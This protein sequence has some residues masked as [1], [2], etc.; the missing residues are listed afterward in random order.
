MRLSAEWL[1]AGVLAAVALG[2]AALLTGCDDDDPLSGRPEVQADLVAPP[3]VP[4][5]IR[6]G[7]AHVVVDLFVEE[8]EVEIAPGVQYPVWTFNGSVPGPMIR[9]RVGDQVEVR[10]RNPDSSTVV[11]NIDLHSVNGP[12]GGAGATNVAPGEESGFFFEAKAPGLYVY[13]CA[14][15]IVADHIANGMYGA[16]LVEPTDG[17]DEVDREYYVGQS[18]FYTTGDNGDE[19]EQQLDPDKLLAEA[20]EYV[21]FN[22]HAN[23]L[24][25]AG[26]LTA[27]TGERVRL[28]VA[29]GGPNFVSSF[30]VIGEIFDRIY[31]LGSF[32]AADSLPDVQTVLVP[33]GGSAVVE[34]KVDVPGDYRLVDHSLSRVA[35]GAL[36]ILRVSG[37]DDPQ[38]FRPFEGVPAG[39]GHDVV[40]AASGDG[41]ATDGDGGTGGDGTVVAMKD[42][43]FEPSELTA[44]AGTAVTFSLPNEG[45]VPHNMRIAGPDDEYNT[46]DDIVSDPEI[47]G[48]GDDGE[49]TWDLPEAGDFRFRC[50]IHPVEMVGTITV[51]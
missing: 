15:G 47:I 21:L 37:E 19:G 13:H 5:P 43:L 24:Q 28:Y 31:N 18:E 39:D 35:K 8:K 14:A 32:D 46:D 45:R 7:A 3:G 34:F 20:P 2:G 9:V 33:S 51:Q 50:D 12:G 29:N 44:T 41:D 22:G 27:E 23:S 38:V 25:E 36:G 26:V 4:E 11:H 42:N 16:I 6:R 48:A 1:R 30:H 10:L 17:L 40:D 49:L